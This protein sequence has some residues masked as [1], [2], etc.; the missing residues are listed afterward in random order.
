[1]TFFS[2]WFICAIVAA[3]VASSRGRS[4]FG[5]FLIGCIIGI[6]AIILVALLP[7]KNE[8]AI[9]VGGEVATAETHVRCPWC[10]GLVRMDA[11]VCMHCRKELVPVATSPSASE[12]RSPLQRMVDKLNEPLR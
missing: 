9:V 6:F 3:I 11:T 1:M 10:K 4:G 8:R 2:I 12:Y 7:S 5:W